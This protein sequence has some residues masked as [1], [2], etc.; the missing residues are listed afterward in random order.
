MVLVGMVALVGLIG[1]TSE[2]EKG[3][4]VEPTKVEETKEVTV[5]E[6]VVAEAPRSWGDMSQKEK[7]AIDAKKKAAAAQKKL[8]EGAAQSFD[9][10]QELLCVNMLTNEAYMNNPEYA[11]PR[12]ELVA[13]CENDY[14]ITPENAASKKAQAEVDYMRK[15]AA[16]GQKDE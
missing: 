13:K 16:K 9:D 1:C 8:R 14:G 5:E 6:T 11:S 10:P 7:D 15:Q 2:A 3:V 12:Q 4:P